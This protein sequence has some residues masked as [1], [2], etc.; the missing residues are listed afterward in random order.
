MCSYHETS[1][2]DEVE[3]AISRVKAISLQLGDV[4]QSLAVHIQE[5]TI[6]SVLDHLC[7]F[8]GLCLCFI[9]LSARP[10]SKDDTTDEDSVAS[11]IKQAISALQGTSL[12]VISLLHARVL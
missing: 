1:S 3:E 11:Q 10:E 7:L 12:H 4:I 8:K 6:S 9:Q 2:A 5:V